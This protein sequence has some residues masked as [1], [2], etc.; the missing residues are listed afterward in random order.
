MLGSCARCIS[1]PRQSEHIKLNPD[2]KFGLAFNRHTT[3]PARPPA[4][5]ANPMKR[6]NRA[7]HTAL[8]SP[9]PSSPL[10]LSLSMR[11]MIRY[12]SREQMPGIQSTK[13]T[14]TGGSVSG[15]DPQG[16]LACAD[17]IAASKNVQFAR[18]N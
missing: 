6:N 18:A 15:G 2:R 5:N 17:R 4:M 10:T 16:D 14:W 1:K 8:E 11:L 3:L 13:V 12:P 9:N 7:L